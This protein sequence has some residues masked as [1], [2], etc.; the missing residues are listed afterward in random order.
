MTDP[1]VTDACKRMR[2]WLKQFDGG[3]IEVKPDANSK[4]QLAIA[5]LMQSSIKRFRL[6][7]DRF[8]AQMELSKAVVGFEVDRI[9]DDPRIEPDENFLKFMKSAITPEV[10][11]ASEDMD[12]AATDL[13]DCITQARAHGMV[14]DGEATRRKLAECK[15]EV[16]RL[17]NQIAQYKKNLNL[18][19]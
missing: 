18:P 16:K 7:T 12:K 4:L 2:Q 6:A 9:F 10:R 1:L 5:D 19:Q 3:D 8:K 11:I 17:V 13:E 15:E 14:H